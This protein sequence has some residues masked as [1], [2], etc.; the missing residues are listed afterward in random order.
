MGIEVPE[1]CLAYYKCNEPFS[2]IYGS[3]FFFSTHMQRSTDKH[4][5]IFHISILGYFSSVTLLPL[6]CFLPL[7]TFSLV[8]TFYYALYIIVHQEYVFFCWVFL[9][10]LYMLHS[11]SQ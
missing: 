1:T 7:I 4:T 9:I 11:F 6:V 5:L 2:A 10:L 3:W 8:R